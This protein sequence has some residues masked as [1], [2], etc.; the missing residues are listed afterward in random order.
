MPA[1]DRPPHL[2]PPLP[3]PVLAGA[4]F[5]PRHGSFFGLSHRT[6]ARAFQQG[7]LLFLGFVFLLDFFLPPPPLVIT[8]NLL[9]VIWD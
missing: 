9:S 3:F 4:W 1:E 2:Q 6:R 8:S 7:L 5:V